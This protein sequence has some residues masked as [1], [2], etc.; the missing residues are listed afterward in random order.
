MGYDAVGAAIYDSGRFP[1]HRG[2]LVYSQDK[3]RRNFVSA[4]DLG[5]VPRE[6]PFSSARS[7][8]AP[9]LLHRPALSARDSS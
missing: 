5:L 7:A 1:R 9:F 6:F 3:R 4:P 8:A 2:F